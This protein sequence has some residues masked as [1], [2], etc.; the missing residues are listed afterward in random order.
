MNKY[1]DMVD[2]LSY[3]FSIGPVKDERTPEQKLHDLLLRKQ[4]GPAGMT[5]DGALLEIHG[6][7]N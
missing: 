3:C 6:Q 5:W 1:D 2:A 4:Y 7:I